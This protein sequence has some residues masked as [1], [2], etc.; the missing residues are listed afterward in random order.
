MYQKIFSKKFKKSMRKIVYSG[1][2]RREEIESVLDMLARGDRLTEKYQ[3]HALQGSFEGFRECHVRPDLL[4]IYK[5]E[6]ELLILL[7]INIGSHSEL[8]G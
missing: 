4:L 3:D 5:K 6:N 1:T 7:L 2:I 8:F